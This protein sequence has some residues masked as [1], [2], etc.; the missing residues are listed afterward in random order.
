MFS[1]EFVGSGVARIFGGV[2][3]FFLL[4]FGIH[5]DDNPVD[6]VRQII[7]FSS[8]VMAE[9]ENV[10]GGFA[11]LVLLVYFEAETLKG[12][13]EFFLGFRLLIKGIFVEGIEKSVE[14][15]VCCGL[16]VE[17]ADSAGSGI[18]GVDKGFGAFSF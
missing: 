18:A 14:F 13:E 4:G 9:F 8:P 5:F 2:A 15:A 10:G 7:A 17:L 3:E 12:F 11:V 6:F 1:G 16:G